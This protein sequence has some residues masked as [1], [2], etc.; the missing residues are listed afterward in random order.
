M[1]TTAPAMKNGTI[2]LNADAGKR[3][4]ERRADRR[5]PPSDADPEHERAAALPSSSAR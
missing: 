2:A 3:E 1:S 4:Q 5:A